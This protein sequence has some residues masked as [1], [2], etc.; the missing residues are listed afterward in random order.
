[1]H[2]LCR[3][4]E[5]PRALEEAGFAY[6]ATVGYNDAVGFR[7]GTLQPYRPLGCS[8]LLELPL[9]LQDT[10]LFY[11]DRLALGRPEAWAAAR[12]LLGHARTHGGAL[13]VS[14]HDRSLAP[15]RLWGEFY[16]EL[17]ETLAASEATFLTAREAVSLFRTRRALQFSADG[18]ASVRIDG[19]PEA[20]DFVVRIHR[21]GRDPV[22]EPCRRD[23]VV[24]L[25]AAAARGS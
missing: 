12:V 20:A 24:E 1:M 15:E 18:M 5:T 21:P 25:G 9:H 4:P 17:L 8:Q 16:A 11:P 7:A 10:S 6:D 23:H 22:E 19:A 13:T 2:W 3:R 14:W